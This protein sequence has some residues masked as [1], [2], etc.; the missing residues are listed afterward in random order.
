MKRIILHSVLIFGSIIFS[1]PFFWL[2]L[3]TFKGADE[4]VGGPV[5]PRVPYKVLNSPYIGYMVYPEIE[6][7]LKLE[8][9]RWNELKPRLEEKIWESTYGILGREKFRESNKFLFV[10]NEKEL[11]Q[12]MIEGIWQTI[13]VRLPESIWLEKDDEI[14]SALAKSINLKS[15]EYIFKQIF[16]GFVLKNAILEDNELNVIKLKPK[17]GWIGDSTLTFTELPQGS[18]VLYDFGKNKCDKEITGEFRLPLSEFK[19]LGKIMISFDVDSS[20]HKL[21]FEI[22]TKDGTFFTKDPF[23]MDALKETA[24]T[25]CMGKPKNLDPGDIVMEKSPVKENAQ[26]ADGE[27]KLKIILKKSSFNYA[28]FS[29]FTKSYRDAMKPLAGNT[30]IADFTFN[31]IFLAIIN[32]I[33]QVFSCT[34]IAYAFARIKWPGRDF[35]FILLL[36]TMMLPGQVTMIPL[37]AIFAKMGWYDTLKPLWAPSF[38][39]QAFFIFLLRQFFM[40]IPRELDDAAKID[41]CTHFGIYSKIL[42]PQ[43]KPALATITIFTFMGSWN[44]FMGPLIYLSSLELYP[45]ALGLSFFR[46]TQGSF[47]GLLMAAS[48]LM[49]I[50][51]II[52]FFFAQKYFIQGTTLTGMKG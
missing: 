24:V 45:L 11:R 32:I 6:K 8:Q 3:T 47:W 28:V 46:D 7:P 21:F 41:G 12:E 50:P 35:C 44:N 14:M 30:T 31:S 19:S 15:S 40:T 48:T 38:F 25:L 16:K 1:L 20:F 43:M 9:S 27:V 37:F 26:I 49:I 33:G 13:A 51:I 4:L 10:R 34:L 22:K 39:G 52:I 2:V 29:K 23:V 18:L 42:L 5:L 36:A 17:D